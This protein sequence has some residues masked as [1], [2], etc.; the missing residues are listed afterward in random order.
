MRGPNGEKL[1]KQNGTQ[2]L[3]LRDPLAALRQAAAVLGLPALPDAGGVNRTLQACIE[4]FKHG[5][6]GC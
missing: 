4:L 3:D 5:A 1:S 2:A 6:H